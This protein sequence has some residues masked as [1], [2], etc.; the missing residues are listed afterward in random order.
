ML[1]VPVAEGSSACG[2]RDASSAQTHAAAGSQD[3]PNRARRAG[4]ICPSSLRLPF[5]FPFTRILWTIHTTPPC[6]CVGPSAVGG[7][8]AKGP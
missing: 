3:M 2:I 4:K 8:F 7:G 5:L 6:G 1:V